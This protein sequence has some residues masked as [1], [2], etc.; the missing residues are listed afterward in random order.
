MAE[1]RNVELEYRSI[2]KTNSH[3]QKKKKA[4][5]VTEKGVSEVSKDRKPAICSSTLEMKAG[6]EAIGNHGQELSKCNEK[7]QPTNSR[8]AEKPK[9]GDEEGPARRLPAARPLS[10][11]EERP[12][13]GGSARLTR[14]GPLEGKLPGG[15]DKMKQ[16]S[17]RQTGPLQ[18]KAIL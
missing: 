6:T 13:P 12:P 1:A 17:H 10:T 2:K 11:E 7:H 5:H 18:G 9:Q 3:P 8:N 4:G 15:F 14:P 16:A